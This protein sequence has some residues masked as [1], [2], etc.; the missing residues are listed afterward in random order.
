MDHTFD[1]KCLYLDVWSRRGSKRAYNREGLRDFMTDNNWHVLTR[2]EV[3]KRFF[4]DYR[5]TD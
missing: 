4:E 3:E 5:V 2:K 1:E